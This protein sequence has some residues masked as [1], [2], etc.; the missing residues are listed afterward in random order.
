MNYKDRNL[1][2][3]PS[4]DVSTLVYGKVPPQ[5][6]DLEEVVLGSL[7]MD[8][9][10]YDRISDL[11]KPESFYVDA[12]QRIYSAMRELSNQNIRIEIS[13]VITELKKREELEMVG[14]PYVVTKLT[15]AVVGSVNLEFYAM[16]VQQKYIQ[17]EI[18]R[19]CGETMTAAYED[20]ADAFE[21][22]DRLE[23]EV[24]TLGSQTVQGGSIDMSTA[25]V[26]AMQ[27]INEWRGQDTTLTGVPSGFPNID[28]ATRGWQNG[29][30]IVLAARPAVGKTA[31]MLNLVRNAAL[32]EQ[33][34]VAVAVW[35]LEMGVVELVLRMLAAESEVWLYKIQTGKLTD[36]DMVLLHKAGADK[37]SKARIW[38]DDSPSVTI[39]G[40]KAKARRLK[41]KHNIGI[42]F[43]DYLQLMTG[44]SKGNREQE[45]SN[46]SR[47]MKKLAKELDIPIIALAQLSRDIEKRQGINRKP[48][49]SDLRES[50]AIEQDADLICFLWAPS[51][52]EIA[53]DASLSFRR[54]F[55]IAKQRNGVLI[56]EDFDFK[57]EIQLFGLIEEGIPKNMQN[58]NWKPIPK[59]F[60]QS[61]RRDEDLP[62]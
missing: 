52:E 18:I 23:H 8:A 62:F 14:G 38:F 30:L 54:Y 39:S 27:K 58:Q 3:R 29:N 15:N 50:G 59:D 43:V 1:R 47:E 11:L 7:M 25:I 12:N 20:S 31:F 44:E 53:Q 28:K 55:R 21:L 13:S 35:S 10:S 61:N 46:I 45:V 26:Q 42:I 32:N 51:E 5:A 6:K 36:D 49:L 56:T 33:K 41:K 24:M 19:V 22:Q 9:N 57:N 40:F 37:L 60:T 34:K 17:R 2:K 48:Q 4:M 16:V